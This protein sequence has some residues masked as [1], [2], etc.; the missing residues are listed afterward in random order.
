MPGLGLGYCWVRVNPAT[1]TLTL[2]L[3]LT[4]TLTQVAPDV[5]DRAPNADPDA[6]R[7]KRGVDVEEAWA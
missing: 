1:L 4:L 2:T 7:R 6:S 3:N 5:L